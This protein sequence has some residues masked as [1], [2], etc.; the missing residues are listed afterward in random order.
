[1]IQ[2]TIS[3]QILDRVITVS[4]FPEPFLNGK[5]SFYN[6]WKDNHLDVILR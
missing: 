5:I 4:G 2:K 3:N 6:K 1:M